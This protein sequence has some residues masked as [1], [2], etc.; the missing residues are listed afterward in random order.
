MLFESCFGRLEKRF[1]LQI[2]DPQG[3]VLHY[4]GNRLILPDQKSARGP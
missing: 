4:P 2:R 1:Q 3:G